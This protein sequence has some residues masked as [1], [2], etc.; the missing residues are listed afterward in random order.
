MPWLKA[1]AAGDIFTELVII[2]LPLIGF[3]KTLMPIKRR[4]TVILAFSTRIPYVIPSFS[5]RAAT[6][7]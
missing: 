3:Y 2:L 1:V 4:F 7:L 5:P 6:D